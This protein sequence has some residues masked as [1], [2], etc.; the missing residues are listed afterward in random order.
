LIRGKQPW[1]C[2][3]DSGSDTPDWRGN[4]HWNAPRARRLSVATR[5]QVEGHIRDDAALCLGRYGAFL[6]CPYPK[7]LWLPMLNLA[8]SLLESCAVILGQ[9][10]CVRKTEHGIARRGILALLKTLSLRS[11]H[12]HDSCG[13]VC[14]RT[15]SAKQAKLLIVCNLYYI[16]R[17]TGPYLPSQKIKSTSHSTPNRHLR[18]AN[19]PFER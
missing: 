10:L 19:V 4:L 17:Y 7:G 3:R 1:L 2:G 18:T 14:P 16:Y 12:H 9:A 5:R 6:T 11:G 13:K 15:R 8:C